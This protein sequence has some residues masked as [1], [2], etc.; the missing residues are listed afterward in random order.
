MFLRSSI[1]ETNADEGSAGCSKVL[2]AYPANGRYMTAVNKRR[3]W[4][5]I[6]AT[7][8]LWPIVWLLV[9]ATVARLKLGYWPSY[10]RPDASNILPVILD[11]PLL[12]LLLVSPLTVM[13][14]LGLALRS[15]YVGRSDWK[16]LPLVTLTSFLILMAWIWFDPG[17]FFTWW[18]DF[19]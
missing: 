2:G 10:N 17:R 12:L 1:S 16:R 14:S 9:A 8:P 13:L 3:R 7:V 6:L 15:W 11:L 18:S 5:L 4:P 19:F